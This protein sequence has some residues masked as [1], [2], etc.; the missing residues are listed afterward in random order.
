VSSGSTGNPKC[1]SFTHGALST[2]I[3]AIARRLDLTERDVL[4]TP[5]PLSVAGVIGM[6]VLPGLL[7]DATV[8]VGRLSGARLALA[9]T[10]VRTARPTLIYGVPYTYEIL[11]RKQRHGGYDRL[12]WAICSSAPL[13]TSTFD[14]VSAC[15]GVPVR[16][17]YCSAEAGT[18][19]LNTC[20]E[21]ESLRTTVGAPLDGVSVKIEPMNGDPGAGR[22]II[23]GTSC[24]AGYRH[25][26]ELT[27]FQSGEVVTGDLGFINNGLL[28][29]TGRVDEV[30]QVAG[31]N[32][33]LARVRQH[34]R[35]CP[36][37]GEFALIVSQHE[38]LG[39]VPILLADAASLTVSPPE[40]MSFCRRVLRDVEVPREVRVVEGIP[41]T[42]T[43]KIQLTDGVSR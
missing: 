42:A 14:R 10:Q 43:G 30:I 6:V 26:G 16:S 31:Q 28:T 24:G 21:P 41:R 8:W 23:G 19:T 11:A 29:L 3:H 13:P 25:R 39:Q 38:R 40:V 17:S 18:V 33:D 9:H 7:R 22:V 1:V 27:P 34:L 4:Y 5:L 20:S 35:R 37:L 15:L 12:R 2:N 36:G 32:V